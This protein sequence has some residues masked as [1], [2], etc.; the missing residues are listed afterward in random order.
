MICMRMTTEIG[1]IIFP[2]LGDLS[3][4]PKGETR[5]LGKVFQ[6]ISVLQRFP[7]C[8]ILLRVGLET[9][10]IPPLNNIIFQAENRSCELVINRAGYNY[11]QYRRVDYLSPLGRWVGLAR[12][13]YLTQ[14]L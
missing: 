7:F 12:I 8:S 1:E 9:F 13:S 4:V 11:F 14:I 3:P 5:N 10:S 2:R 6:P